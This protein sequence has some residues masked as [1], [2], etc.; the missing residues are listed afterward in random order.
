MLIGFIPVSS[1]TRLKPGYTL[2]VE[3]HTP[4]RVY[5]CLWEKG[6]HIHHCLPPS[7]GEREAYTP[8]L[9]TLGGVYPEY[10]LSGGVYPGYSLSGSVY[11][12]GVSLPGGVYT[13][14]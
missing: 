6:R 10:S 7:L 12:G 2:V 3:R 8:L 13:G 14:C 5:L 11:T 1:K 9:Y 4:P